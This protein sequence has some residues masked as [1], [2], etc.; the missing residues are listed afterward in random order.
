MLSGPNRMFFGY[1]ETPEGQSV[2]RVLDAFGEIVT[3]MVSKEHRLPATVR[4]AMPCSAVAILTRDAVV[5][6][7]Q[8]H[9][10]MPKTT[11]LLTPDRVIT[12]EEAL[13]LARWEFGFDDPFVVTLP[14]ALLSVSDLKTDPTLIAVA[15]SHVQAELARVSRMTQIVPVNPV[16]GPAAFA[17]D[18][19]LAFT[20]MPFQ[21][22]LTRIYREIIKP[23]VE[24]AGLVCKRAD[25]YRSNRV[26]MQDIWKAICEAR[27]VIADLTGLNPNVMYELGIAHTVGK[28][29]IL[30]FQKGS[31][32]SFPFDLAHIRRIE[33]EDSAIGGKA[34]ETALSETLTEVLRP[35]AVS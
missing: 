15:K 12:T 9:L 6:M 3:E 24:R 21:D 22:P 28:T 25:D 27:V 18:P 14:K 8:Q 33:Y 29:T 34:L 5:V 13:Y 35:V 20:L 32:V 11:V 10:G 30:I 1:Q 2:L 16:F 23:T 26:V 7:A 17:L 19:R 31:A 4:T